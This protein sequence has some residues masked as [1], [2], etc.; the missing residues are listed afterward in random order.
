M[1]KNSNPISAVIITHNVADTIGQCLG[2][3][4]KVSDDIVVLDSFSDDGT[5]E[6]CEKL[7]VRLILQ[8]WLGYSQTKNL[9]NEIATNDW[10][11]SIDSDEMLSEELVASL[12]ELK[13]LDRHVYSLDRL[14]NF[15]G[16]WIHHSGW[17]PEW[18]IRLFNKRNVKW[19]GDYVHETL[20][21]P[22]NFN[23]IKVRGKLFHYSYKDKEDHFKRIRK[24]ARLSALERFEK[25]NKASFSKVWL[26]PIAR[27]FR[28]Y[29]LKKG[30]LDGK[31]GFIISCRSAY[32]VWLRYTILKN[33][34]L[35][36]KNNER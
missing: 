33:L 4:K 24:Y 30:I 3:L 36:N 26:S 25:G 12:N 13:L 1:I 6:I 9:G 14:T 21:I 20:K 35:S 16:K 31:E 19:H 8:E 17:Y 18:K 10:I 2:A 7:G 32:M 34:W 23:E 28:T 11:L 27:F 29:I 22:V 15:C 5:I